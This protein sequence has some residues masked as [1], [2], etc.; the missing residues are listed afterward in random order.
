MKETTLR[1]FAGIIRTKSDQVVSSTASELQSSQEQTSA[2][3]VAGHALKRTDVHG[4]TGGRRLAITPRADQRVSFNDLAD[5]PTNLARISAFTVGDGTATVITVTH[6]RGTR[7]VLVRV[8]DTATYSDVDAT[9][10]STTPDMITL[11]F[12]SAPAV[13]GCRVVIMA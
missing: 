9:V 10:E 7:D 5:T 2:N 1:R 11:T 12:S 4:A 3:A 13:D 6:R 8:Y